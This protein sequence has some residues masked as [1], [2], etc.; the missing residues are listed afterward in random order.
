MIHLDYN[1]AY[2][3]LTQA[4]VNQLSVDQER[5]LFV[6][7]D[8]FNDM[9]RNIYLEKDRQ[10]FVFKI[11]FTNIINGNIYI[12]KKNFYPEEL[13]DYVTLGL[14]DRFYDFYLENR[15]NPKY[16]NIDLRA[17]WYFVQND[18]TT[19]LNIK[20]VRSNKYIFSYKR[21]CE[22]YDHPV[23]ER[24]DIQVCCKN[25]GMIHDIVTNT[26]KCPNHFRKK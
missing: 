7:F 10:N 9:V 1:L 11:E 15:F 23:K 2:Y 22:A 18:K 3:K 13:Y 12:V 8:Y 25:I 21:M 4:R 6:D 17:V 20:W 24:A 19:P 26:Y 5:Y 16:K 14:D